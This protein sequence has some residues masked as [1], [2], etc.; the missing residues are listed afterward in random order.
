MNPVPA[1]QQSNPES[2]SPQEQEEKGIVVE[3]W[4]YWV[5]EAVIVG[6]AALIVTISLLRRRSRREKTSDPDLLD[7]DPLVDLGR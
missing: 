6:I 1:P 5:G 7:N 2:V 3:P 4:V